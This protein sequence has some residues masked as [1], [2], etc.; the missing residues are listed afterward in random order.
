MPII[1]TATKRYIVNGPTTAGDITFGSVLEVIGPDSWTFHYQKVGKLYFGLYLIRLNGGG[2]YSLI[3]D[4]QA[5]LDLTGIFN[6]LDHVASLLGLTVN[7][8]YPNS[9]DINNLAIPGQ[10]QQ[11]PLGSGAGFC[12]IWNGSNYISTS[13]SNLST[14][15]VGFLAN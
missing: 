14:V 8:Y 1:P 11:N 5:S 3:G 6:T 7:T 10:T 4:D 13:A 9:L 15:A 12:V 2:Q